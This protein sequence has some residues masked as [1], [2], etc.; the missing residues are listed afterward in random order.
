MV[1]LGNTTGNIIEVCLCL[2]DQVLRMGDTVAAPGQDGVVALAVA[3]T[4]E[5][6]CLPMLLVLNF[7]SHENMTRKTMNVDDSPR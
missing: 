6:A 7:L 4:G 3:A 2:I 5:E 1:T